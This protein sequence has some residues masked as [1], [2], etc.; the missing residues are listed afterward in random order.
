MTSMAHA[1]SRL[2][3]RQAGREGEWSRQSSFSDGEGCR[4]RTSCGKWTRELPKCGR[5]LQEDKL[6]RASGD[7]GEERKAD[8]EA[9]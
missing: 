5:D 7:D 4:H 9:C 3:A 2:S 8:D 1:H 6:A